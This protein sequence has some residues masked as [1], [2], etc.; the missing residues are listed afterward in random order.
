MS[1]NH[2]KIETP[3]GLGFPLHWGFQQKR[4]KAYASSSPSLFEDFGVYNA[5][6]VEKSFAVDRHDFQ[7][8]F[9]ELAK[10]LRA[11]VEY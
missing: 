3:F 10:R 4:V 7:N 5:A 11:N 8:V 6:E 1:Q 9:L 2:L